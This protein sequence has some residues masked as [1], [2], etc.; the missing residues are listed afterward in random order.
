MGLGGYTEE[1]KSLE[2]IEVPETEPVKEK[3][4][5]K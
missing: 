5:E 3:E 2:E 4:D 1:P